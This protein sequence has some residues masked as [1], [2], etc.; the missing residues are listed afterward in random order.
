MVKIPPESFMFPGRGVSLRGV[1]YSRWIKG[2]LHWSKWPRAQKSARTAREQQTRDLFAVASKVTLHMSAAEQAFARNLADESKLL[3][4]DFLMIALFNRIGTIVRR[5][6]SKVY[7]VPAI[8]DV[9][10][11]LDAL[12]QLK[13][14]IL[15]RGETWWTG[16]PAG[17]VGQVLTVGPEQLPQWEEAQ[18]GASGEGWRQM[19]VVQATT[20]S[21]AVAQN[22]VRFRLIYA[23]ED[24]ELNG[25]L[26]LVR[27][28]FG[29]EAASAVLYDANQTSLSIASQTKLAQGPSVALSNGLNTLGFTSP[30]NLVAGTFYYLGFVNTSAANLTQCA[31]VPALGYM[32]FT[33]TNPVCPATAPAAATSNSNNHMSFW[34]Y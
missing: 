32:T 8:Q 29:T 10:D 16:V 26:M 25:I 13:G 5:D 33:N 12:W 34:G 15:V 17:Q 11:L 20:N 28:T 24:Q 6:G 3:P 18:S 4:R 2:Q 19:P 31:T 14:G 23:T 7:S 9:S 30:V 1:G 22:N 21:N 27:N